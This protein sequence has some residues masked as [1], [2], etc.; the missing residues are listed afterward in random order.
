[1][2]KGFTLIELLVV[3]AIIAILAGMLLPALNSARQRARTSACQA[4]L[5]QY[6]FFA[7]LYADDYNDYVLPHSLSYA[8][9]EAKKSD[10][11]ADGH[12]RLAPY[13]IFRDIG[14]A[15]KWTAS[16]SKSIF[17]CPASKIGT[18]VWHNLYNGRVYGIPL[19][20]TFATK[21][22]L[23]SGVKSIAKLQKVKNPSKQA[24]CSVNKAYDA[25]IENLTAAHE[26][27]LENIINAYNAEENINNLRNIFRDTIIDAV[28]SGEKNYPTSVYYMDVMNE[29]ERMG[30]FMINISQNLEKAF[31]A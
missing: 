4:N 14:Y 1:M 21:K 17:I 16:T 23:Q 24:Y 18:S 31:R 3:I 27:R 20:L 12:H 22:D 29:Y 8:G 25:M 15:E 13:Q 11:Y 7:L 19:G 5:K 2:K 26:G 9:F 28:D 10:S 30:D 6:V